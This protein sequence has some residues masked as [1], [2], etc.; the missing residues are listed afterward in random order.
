MLFYLQPYLVLGNQFGFCFVICG[1][2]Y[3]MQSSRVCV[4]INSPVWEY[5][6][7]E[8]W[9]ELWREGTWVTMKQP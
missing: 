8:G 9:I 7:S 2:R 4:P 6:L 3:E 5:Y 1:R